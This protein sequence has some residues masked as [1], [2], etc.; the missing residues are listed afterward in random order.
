[1]RK[2]E[3]ITNQLKI[4]A[5]QD[6]IKQNQ[7][8][9]DLLLASQETILAN[10]EQ[11]R[12]LEAKLSQL[13]AEEERL[14]D[15]YDPFGEM[16]GTSDE[17][18][19]VL[20]EALNVAETDTTVLLRGETGTGKELLAHAI[21]SH[22]PRKHRPFIIVNC[23][24][25]PSSLI[26]S[27]LFGYEK[28][29]FTGASQRKAGRFELAD[30][31]TIFLDEIGEVP[32]ETQGR[33]LR[34][35][36]TGIFERL[37]ST[38]SVRVK[39]RIIAATNQPLE[40]LVSQRKFRADLYYRLNIFPITLPPLRERT[41]DIPLLVRYFVKKYSVRFNRVINSIHEQSLLALHD[42][43]WPGNIR[44]LENMIERS[45]LTAETDLLKIKLPDT[46]LEPAISINDELNGSAISHPT[47]ASSQN[48]SLRPFQAIT[49][50][51]NE[52]ALIQRTLDH[53]GGR[54]SG[55][56]GAAEILGLPASTLRSRIKKLGL[57]IPSHSSNT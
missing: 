56:H 51:E 39:V 21:H 55:P 18:Q 6:Q 24:A 14:T 2:D 35:I 16:I 8:K 17:F 44:E 57:N 34:V 53:T 38:K 26:E 1:M 7:N 27:E 40:R 47:H 13:L 41:A 15:E 37:G 23:A 54:I 10:Q 4:L 42:Y 43:H 5:N 52:R 3:V 20:R 30:G 49:L 25:L 29:A 31:G 32:L 22:S 50:A 28:G 36:Q 9:L 12:E 46:N 45:I 33:F 48:N 11:I 19:R